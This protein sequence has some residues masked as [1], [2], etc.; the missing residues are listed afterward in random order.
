[1]KPIRRLLALLLAAVLTLSLSPLTALADPEP[2][3][4]LTL[5]ADTRII[6]EEAFMY[7]N[8]FA[9][10]VLPDGIREI[11]ARAF[12]CTALQRINLPASLTFIDDEAFA[13]INMLEVTAE[14]G[15]YAY[16]WAVEHGYL[17]GSVP[18]DSENFPDPIF[19]AYVQEK[20][21]S[22]KDGYLS[23]AECDAVEKIAVRARGITDLSGVACFPNLKELDC[24]YNAI[25]QIDVTAN[26]QLEMLDVSGVG[27]HAVYTG[28]NHALKRLYC[29][30]NALSEL[31]V[32]DNPLLEDLD[33]S[34]NNLEML[35]VSQNPALRRL[36]CARNSGITK[37]DVANNSVLERLDCSHCGL[38]SL[39]VMNNPC[40]RQLYC[41][42]N[43]LGSLDVSQNTVLEALYCSGCVLQSLILSN[44]GQL[45]ELDCSDNRLAALDLSNNSKLALLYCGR[46]RL[47]ALTTDN[48][49][50]LASLSC[51]ENRIT[52]LDLQNNE[53]L[54]SLI[55][56]GNALTALDVT[57]TPELWELVCEDNPIE[58][59]DITGCERL[60]LAYYRGT[61]QEMTNYIE[62]R[63]S[64][65]KGFLRLRYPASADVCGEFPGVPIDKIYFPDDVL[66]QYIEEE[67]DDGD[68]ELSPDELDAVTALNLSGLQIKGLGGIQYF[69][70]LRSLS[71]AGTPSSP[72]VLIYADLQY[73]TALVSVDFRYNPLQNIYIHPLPLLETLLLDGTL[74]DYMSFDRNPALE[75]LS[76]RGC[77]FSELDVSENE[78]LQLLDC[79]G[80]TALHFL[81]LRNCPALRKAVMAGEPRS[82]GS[83]SLL[84]GFS[85]DEFALAVDEGVY[86]ISDPDD[87]G[88]VTKYLNSL[89]VNSSKLL[90]DED[91]IQNALL[92]TNWSSSNPA[93]GWCAGIVYGELAT[94]G[95]PTL[96]VMSGDGTGPVLLEGTDE[97]GVVRV[98]IQFWV[99]GAVAESPDGKKF[100]YIDAAI[101]YQRDENEAPVTLLSDAS[102]RFSAGQSLK[103]YL[104]G[105]I[106]TASTDKSCNLTRS[107]QGSLITYTCTRKPGTAVELVR[108]DAV[109]D[110]SNYLNDL[111]PALQSG[112]ILRLN[113]DAYCDGYCALPYQGT[114]T[115]LLNSYLVRSTEPLYLSD[116]NILL[117]DA[118]LSTLGIDLKHSGWPR[119]PLQCE[120]IQQTNGASYRITVEPAD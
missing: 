6:D 83:G 38:E 95:G 89:E 64:A 94:T 114:V 29:A 42:G 77:Q 40:L 26:R 50:Q 53:L 76:V 99:Y 14:E 81:D 22:D 84:Y 86:V 100:E 118:P 62:H 12:A 102:Y 71:C 48:L 47:T 115:L 85:G 23:A 59:L 11:R 17:R 46:N 36:M 69:R 2:S 49:E 78:A 87:P 90:M 106:F 28:E 66:R 58:G 101:C 98:R 7:D 104:D 25:E 68:G 19:R 117:T 79:R 105:Y 75:T 54:T 60:N 15:S 93:A 113:A 92:V 112:D 37:L 43:L 24:G 103:L 56:T 65:G 44:N 73:N 52:S 57:Y 8:G 9:E 108:G 111:I 116:S 3:R 4:V 33:C 91:V 67:I 82:D 110:S 5:P 51:E 107:Q 45:V 109:I 63:Y 31:D 74:V 61:R 72:G 35:I 80:N 13:Q 39:I 119:R 30:N 32:S 34:G 21:D 16:K 55:C 120:T 20:F 41:S 27:T 70:N 18:I 10:V 96:K 1:M 97:N 88:T